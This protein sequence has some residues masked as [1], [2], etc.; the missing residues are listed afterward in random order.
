M[1][2]PCSNHQL[3][4]I[5]H[6]FNRVSGSDGK[7]YM[8]DPCHTYNVEQSESNDSPCTRKNNVAICQNSNGTLA[9][10]GEMTTVSYAYDPLLKIVEIS[11]ISAAQ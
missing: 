2:L 5:S 4:C 11:Y 7:T 6:S 3:V 8:W 1:K 10:I 9:N